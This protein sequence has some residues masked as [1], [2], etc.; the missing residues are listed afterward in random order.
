VESAQVD[1]SRLEDEMTPL[2]EEE[3]V[4]KAANDQATVA[5]QEA[6]A[7]QRRIQGSIKE[8][9]T[10]AASIQRDIEAEEKRIEDAN[11]GASGRKQAEIDEA[12][13]SVE[14]AKRA[15][16]DSE[17]EG[18]R[19]DG[20]V[21]RAEKALTEADVPLSFKVQEIDACRGELLH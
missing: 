8:N 15:L 9:K 6:Q 2:R 16:D 1:V 13:I 19:L 7:E 20:N 10:K 17:S 3:E 14:M 11:G 21:Q 12:R 5:V 18:K 4:A